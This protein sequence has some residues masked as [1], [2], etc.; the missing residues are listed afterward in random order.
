MNNKIEHVKHVI[1]NIN[2]P[3]ENPAE[4]ILKRITLQD[5]VDIKIYS[6]LKAKLSNEKYKIPNNIG[7]ATDQKSNKTQRI[8]KSPIQKLKIF[9]TQQ[10]KKILYILKDIP[11]YTVVNRDNKII[12]ASPHYV[13]NSNSMEWKKNIF[14]ELFISLEKNH[15]PGINLF[16]LK[17]Q[18]AVFYF[19]SI[20][21]DKYTGTKN[22]GIKIL[23]TGLDEFY[24][25]SRTLQC[26]EAQNQLIGDL[27]EIPSVIKKLFHDKNY[28]ANVKQ[29]YSQNWFQGTPIYKITTKLASKM[30]TIVQTPKTSQEKQNVFFT[31][32]N[33][34]DALPLSAR[35]D[36]I[37][38][39]YNLE[40]LLLELENEEDIEK[41]NITLVPPS[42]SQSTVY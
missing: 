36:L 21:M 2:K 11:I 5:N 24:R 22:S 7:E 39:V 10:Q 18:D 31:M 4:Y 32:K 30:H 15:D 6:K 17:R 27:E 23:K 3:A 41:Q 33:V 25:L 34:T 35:K 1:F 19:Q 13:N 40:S 9:P 8:E 26:D 29:K 28:R 42:N 12:T 37:I 14:K 38:E 16:F 20:A